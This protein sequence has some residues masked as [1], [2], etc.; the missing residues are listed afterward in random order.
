MFIHG[1]FGNAN[2]AFCCAYLFIAYFPE[3]APM[4]DIKNARMIV[5]VV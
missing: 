3:F 2:G 1:I 4:N 5:F